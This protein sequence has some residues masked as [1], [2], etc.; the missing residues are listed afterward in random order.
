MSSGSWKWQRSVL[1]LNEKS[2]TQLWCLPARAGAAK[3]RGWDL[4]N[5][6]ARRA[7]MNPINHRQS[8]ARSLPA[9]S[10]GSGSCNP[11]CAPAGPA[12]CA[13]SRSPRPSVTALLSQGSVR[14]R[15]RCLSPRDS[16]ALQ[17]PWNAAG[18]GKGSGWDVQSC[19]FQT[20]TCPLE[21]RGTAGVGWEHQLQ[22]PPH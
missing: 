12:G 8:R 1:H 5:G 19:S 9:A 2:L 7:L 4:K 6:R 11:L 15:G 22:V 10:P 18:T 13:G 17:F 20:P 3:A 16:T 14:T 21:H